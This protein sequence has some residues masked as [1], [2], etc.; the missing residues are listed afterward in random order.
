MVLKTD[1]NSLYFGEFAPTIS[2]HA[3]KA[4]EEYEFECEYYDRCVCLLR[5]ERNIAMPM[6]G[7]EQ[8]L[9]NR[10]ARK[11]WNNVCNKYSLSS[12]DLK[13]ALE[14]WRRHYERC[15]GLFR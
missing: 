12:K 5:N 2:E 3:L 4:A 15:R 10:N 13:D 8:G 9:I 14:H 7:R 11:V 1:F 6:N